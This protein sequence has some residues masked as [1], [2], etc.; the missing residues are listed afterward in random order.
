VVTTDGQTLSLT[1]KPEDVIT[2]LSTSQQ[3][4]FA[5]V[6]SRNRLLGVVDF[7]N[8]RHFVFSAFKVKYSKME[9][10]MTQPAEIAHIEDSLEM[11]M[12]KFELANVN[13]LVVLKDDRYHGF[14]DKCK[15]L[16]AYRGVLKDMVIE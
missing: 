2:M 3:A 11:I 4:H 1:Q 6:D 12:D 13:Y 9:E 15:V 10:L 5:V 16:E 14:I 7:D 8:I